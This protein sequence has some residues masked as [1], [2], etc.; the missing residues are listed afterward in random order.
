MAPI[1][2]QSVAVFYDPLR[3]AIS[4][5]RLKLSDEGTIYVLLLLAD[6]ADHPPDGP[7][8]LGEAFIRA[9]AIEGKR[10]RAL[11]FQAV[12]DKALLTAGCWWQHLA[13][14][15]PEVDYFIELGAKAY[16]QVDRPPFPELARKFPKVTNTLAETMGAFWTPENILHAYSVWRHTKNP[17]LAKVLGRKG[18][19]PAAF[20]PRAE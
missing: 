17:F 3:E 9:E 10:Q 1:S 18:I 15:G 5:Q 14:N 4:S 12:G 13:K 16:R 6:Q 20:A 2:R 7:E 8:I 19:G 11:R